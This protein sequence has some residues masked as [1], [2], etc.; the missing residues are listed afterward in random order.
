MFGYIN[1][2]KEQ[3]GEDYEVFCA[4]YCGLCKQLGKSCSQTSRLGLSYD[5]TFLAIVL[6]SVVEKDDIKTEKHCAIHPVKKR[7]CVSYNKVLDY[8]AKIACILSYEKCLDDWHDEKSIKAIFGMAMYRRAYRKAQKSFPEVAH[9]IQ[10]KLSQLSTIECENIKDID[11]AA[12][13]FAQILS[14]LFS[15]EFIGDNNTLRQLE[16]FGYN[17]G[18]WIYII[19]AINDLRDDYKNGAYNALL[20]DN[21]DNIDEYYKSII[22]KEE[23]AL[24]FTLENIASTFDLMKLYKNSELLRKMIYISLPQKQN[25]ILGKSGGENGSL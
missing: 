21:I 23:F 16:W 11:M 1:A 18:R 10:E 13:S 19:D 24:T 2:T 7:L 6:S 3:L 4:Y 5:I 12:D 17:V 22:Q 15:P 9:F 20:Q 14:K 8:C 25:H